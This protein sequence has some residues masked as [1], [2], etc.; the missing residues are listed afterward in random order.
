MKQIREISD[1]SQKPTQHG[2]GLRRRRKVYVIGRGLNP[3]DGDC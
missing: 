2:L 1:L 3:G